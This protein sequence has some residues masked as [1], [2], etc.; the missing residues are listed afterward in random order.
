MGW[1]F[2]VVIFLVRAVDQRI[3]NSTSKNNAAACSAVPTKSNCGFS[4]T[5]TANSWCGVGVVFPLAD[6]LL[7]TPH[8]PIPL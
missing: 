1:P 4:V 7:H 2:G 3:R 6:T 8:Y 5:P